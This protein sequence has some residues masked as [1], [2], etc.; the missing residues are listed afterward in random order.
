L[1]IVFERACSRA[2]TEASF[3]ARSPIN[4]CAIQRKQRYQSTF[5]RHTLLSTV[6]RVRH[7]LNTLISAQRRGTLY[8][9]ARNKVHGGCSICQHGSVSSGALCMPLRKKPW[10]C[11]VKEITR[12]SATN[13]PACNVKKYVTSSRRTSPAQLS[14]SISYCGLAFVHVQ[15]VT[16][17]TQPHVHQSFRKHR[18]MC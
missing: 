8:N 3:P 17:I 10:H 4:G 6:S 7:V 18:D 16:L 15:A 14:T 12:E 1:E 2:S 13:T 11:R 9:P 5:N